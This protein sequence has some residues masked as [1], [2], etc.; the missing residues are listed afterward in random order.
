MKLSDTLEEQAILERLIE[1]TKPA[2]PEACRH[3]GFLLF[4]PFR[5]NPYPFNSRFRR[6]GSMDGVFYA[7]E[8]PETAVAEKAFYRLLFFLESPGVPWPANPGEYTAFAAHFATDHAADLT[9]PPWLKD[10]SRWTHPTD[11]SSCLDF[12][13]ACRASGLEVIR[14]ESVRDPAARANVASLTCCVFTRNDAVDRQTWR[15]H[16]SSSGIRA[17]CEFPAQTIRFDRKAFA[18]DPRMADM[19]WDR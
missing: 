2:I 14:Y 16:F 8:A 7:A 1:E 10:R 11:Y 6:S 4:T 17:I 18:N 12:A 13:D 5:Y 15:F 19:Q 3:L 9:Q